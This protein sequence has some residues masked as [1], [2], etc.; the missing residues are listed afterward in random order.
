MRAYSN[1]IVS[2]LI[3]GSGQ[4]TMCNAHDG[5]RT[6]EC[7]LWALLPKRFYNRDSIRIDSIGCSFKRGHGDVGRGHGARIE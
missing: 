5:A 7:E 1:E 4:D 2:T 6:T 3:W